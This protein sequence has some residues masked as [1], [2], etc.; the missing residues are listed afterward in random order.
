M[1]RLLCGNMAASK[2][3]LWKYL[4]VSYNWVNKYW[5]S[6]V[7]IYMS[8]LVSLSYTYLILLTLI[9]VVQGINNCLH[10]WDSLHS[11]FEAITCYNGTFSIFWFTWYF[12]NFSL[13]QVYIW[14]V[15]FLFFFSTKGVVLGHLIVTLFVPIFVFWLILISW[16]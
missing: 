5:I 12:K 15:R 10:K 11:S 8:L 6:S 14:N 9:V 16:K 1:I 7:I 3:W 13:L 4:H 2:L